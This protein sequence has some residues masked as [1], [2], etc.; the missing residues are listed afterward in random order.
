MMKNKPLGL[1]HK[2]KGLRN[3]N[4]TLAVVFLFDLNLF[5]NEYRFYR[6]LVSRGKRAVMIGADDFGLAH[7]V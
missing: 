4:T 3:K 6:A 1:S 7:G 2:P 5:F